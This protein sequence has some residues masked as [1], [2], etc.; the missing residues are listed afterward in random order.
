M[1]G[2]SRLIS[3]VAV[4]AAVVPQA[5]GRALSLWP[6]TKLHTQMQI[7]RQNSSVWMSTLEMSVIEQV[8]GLK[9]KHHTRALHRPGPL[10]VADCA[11]SGPLCHN[12]RMGLRLKH[13]LVLPGIG[14][15]VL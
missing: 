7:A 5:C 6:S 9:A 10:N 3:L 12:A 2:A 14:C 4:F 11:V 15:Y 8:R 1:A 13:C